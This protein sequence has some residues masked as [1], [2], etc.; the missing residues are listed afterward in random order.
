MRRRCGVLGS[1][2]RHSL[3]PALHRAGYAEVGLD[4]EYDAHEVAS[5][6][7]PDFLDGLDATWRGLSLTMPLKREA[8]PLATAV[9]DVAQLAGG[10]NT[11][12][13][14]DDGLWA[15]DNTD[16]PGL[17]NALR[18]RW[19][20]PVSRTA[21]LGGGATAASALVALAS[22]GCTEFVLAVRDPE[23]VQDTLAAAERLPTPVQV[24]V[25]ELGARVEADLV[26]STI[27]AAAQMPE[28]VAAAASV[29]VTFEVIYDPWPTP[30]A[31]AAD[32]RVLIGGL[33][34]LVHQAAI[35]FTAFTGLPAPLARMR[36]AG[37]TA[38]TRR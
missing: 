21:I 17:V 37:Q 10:A 8:L 33:D 3:S 34:L 32:D 26:V 38:L 9:S 36:A 18:E 4:W 35:Q 20:A 2:I 15:A 27:P 16:V 25:A 13:R 24:D 19:P 31:A 11:L 1:P 22:T 6:G 28:V 7:L 14:G 5:G 23:R 12:V 30:L 29:P